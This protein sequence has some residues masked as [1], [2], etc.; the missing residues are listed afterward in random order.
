MDRLPFVM[1]TLTSRWT[2]SLGGWAI[3]SMLIWYLFPL[4]PALR[5]PLPRIAAIALLLLVCIAANAILARRRRRREG[6]LA[7]AMTGGARDGKETQA[8]ATEEVA[9]LRERMKQ[10][11][12]RLRR[13][14][15]RHLYEQPWFV[16]IGPPGAGKTTALLN[17]GLHFPLARDDEAPSVSGL[18]GTRLCD[19]WFADEAVLIDTAG[20]YTTQDSDAAVDRAGWQGFLD[21]LRRTRPRQ[22]LNGVIVVLSLVELAAAEPAERALHARS[23]RLRIDEITERLRSRVPVYVVLSKADQLRGF[24]AFF[25]DLDEEGRAQVWGMTLPLQEGVESFGR[26][27]GLL[28]VRLDGR[29]VERLQAERAADRRALIGSFPLQVASLQRPIDEFLHACFAGGRLDP[30][31]FLRGIYLTSATQAGTPIDRLTGAL[32]RSFGLDQ[33]HVPAL[34]PVTGRSFFIKRLLR[35]VVLGEALLVSHRPGLA[36]RRRLRRA[37]GFSAVGVATLAVSLLLW[38]DDAANRVAIEHADEALAAYGQVVAGTRLDPVDDDDLSRV[39][40]VL[41]AAADL[42]QASPRRAAPLGLSQHDK[43]AQSDRLVYSHALQ[44][45][46]LPRLIHRLEQQMRGRFGDAD[47]LYQATR[48][49]LTLGGA[50]PMDPDLIRAWMTDDWNARYPGALN[51]PLRTRLRA[52]L[53]RLLAEPLPPV[54]LDGALVQAARATFSR[55]SL[56]QRVYDRVQTGSDAQSLGDW[57]PASALGDA[58]VRLFTRLSGK[59]LN[60]GVPGF[61]TATGYD[62]LLH[63]LP[64][65]TQAIAG[66]SWV[67]GRDE[68]IPT[69]GPAVTA[70]ERSVVG[71]WSA[72][73]EAH[74][75]A[76]FTDLALAPFG[77]GRETAMQELYV[78]SSPQSPARDLLTGIVRALR[79]NPG[80]AAKPATGSAHATDTLAAL[81]VAPANAQTAATDPAAG[82]EAHYRPLLDLVGTGGAAPLDNVL[83][84][85]DGLEAELAAA[86]PGSIT[87]PATLQGSGD[88]VALLDAEAR[89]Q[90][91]PVSSWLRQIAAVGNAALGTAARQTASAAF[92]GAAAGGGAEAPQALCG[93]VVDGKFPFA[94][95][96]GQ[97]APIDDF[98]R[99]FAPGGVLDSFF[100]SQVKPFVDM[101]D[102][103]WRLH[104]LGGVDAPVG[105]SAVASFQQAAAVRDAFFPAGEPQVRFS[106]T[107]R[108]APGPK[109]KLTLGAAS[110]ATDSTEP[111]SFSWPGGDGPST[112]SV[113]FD[114]DAGA[115]L[116]AS[117]PWALF[118]LLADGRLRPAGERR[119]DLTFESDGR[120]ADFILEPG[121]SHNPF[122]HDLLSGFR[123]PVIR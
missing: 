95:S 4:V 8:D 58:G 56:A 93:S 52:H 36:R 82:Y 54:S 9:R 86:S 30:A 110:I 77:G 11:L 116:R 31:P 71:L 14:G 2:Q 98:T 99:L 72:D 76:L 113:V 27:F 55:V 51:A 32:A 115:V 33:K 106:L 1:M 114:G 75:D 7:E 64:A 69:E 70:L 61:Y 119:F 53:D 123:C 87:L 42:P 29:L 46:L 74:W 121:S 63:D 118:H 108:P 18:G 111:V 20:R 17:S 68:R 120:Q 21:L 109:A 122:G 112:A 10:S 48:V 13:G 80:S 22:P 84:L 103:V 12:A 85:I 6:M 3:A 50:G 117:G 81:F 25:D 67:L 44:R 40:P 90:P 94:R 5:P 47:F 88:P 96:S 104:R 37:A 83:R 105:A 73:A 89:R 19:W 62:V 49:Y 28:L 92:A 39:A 107:P 65:T 35:D 41:N 60:D 59:T 100:Q 102:A 15:R 101:S 38:R 26:E 34:R 91:P 66:E 45:I 16:L 97:D 78:L 23:V 79:L 57:T 24:D 43:I